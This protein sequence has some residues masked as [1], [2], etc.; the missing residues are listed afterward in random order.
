M[1]LTNGEQLPEIWGTDLEGNPR[2][3]NEMLAGSWAAL[4]VYRG[5]W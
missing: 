2:T 1:V 5:D 3:A 4:L